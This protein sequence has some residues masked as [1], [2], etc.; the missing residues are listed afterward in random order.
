MAATLPAAGPVLA[1][2]SA[3]GFRES[4]LQSLRC[5]CY[6]TAAIVNSGGGGAATDDEAV[7]ASASP[8]V[9]VRS[10]GL[11][12]ESVIGY[13]ERRLVPGSS[14]GGGNTTTNKQGTGET[15]TEVDVPRSLVSES[16]LRL[17]LDAANAR[18]ARN[19]ERKARFRDQ[20]L[21]MCGAGAGTGAGTGTGT[22]AGVGTAGADDDG[23]GSGPRATN[24]TKAKGSGKGRERGK[25]KKEAAG[26]E[27][28]D[29][30]VR[31]QRMRAEGL[32]RRDEL[33]RLAVMGGLEER[34]SERE[35]KRGGWERGPAM[36]DDI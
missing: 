27:W 3:A 30:E 21:R 25:G 11:A 12:L 31:R 20:L 7:D 22:G 19:E 9:A 35:R 1:A 33:R 14:S 13:V 8:V 2:A 17:L 24:T 34:E 26:E 36:E 4:G 6:A 23:V 16:Y 5:L 29:A 10:A 28:E 32:R 15:E 18:F